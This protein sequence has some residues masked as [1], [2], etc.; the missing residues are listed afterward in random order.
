MMIMRV[1]MMMVVLV[2]MIAVLVVRSSLHLSCLCKEEPLSDFN[3]ILQ[4]VRMSDVT[5]L[6]QV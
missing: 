1:I 3:P 5:L 6:S 4:L 2:V